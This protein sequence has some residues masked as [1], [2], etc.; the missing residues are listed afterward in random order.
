MYEPLRELWVD[1]QRPKLDEEQLSENTEARL[2]TEL[3]EK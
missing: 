3:G 2:Y 1:W